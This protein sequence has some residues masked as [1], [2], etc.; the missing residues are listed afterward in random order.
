MTNGP[1]HYLVHLS[2]F[3][4]TCQCHTT[5]RPSPPPPQP[6]PLLTHF[7]HGP[8]RFGDIKGLANISCSGLCTEGHFCPLGSALPTAVPCGNASVYCPTGSG[9]PVQ[10]GVWIVT[11]L[12]LRS[13]LTVLQYLECTA[14]FAQPILQASCLHDSVA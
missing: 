3:L 2:G 7:R 4:N 6:H 13:Q 5:A 9:S 8:G 1:M 12:S 14:R 11:S 10:A